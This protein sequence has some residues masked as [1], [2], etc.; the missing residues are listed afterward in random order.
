M[1]AI[2]LTP[3]FAQQTTTL[4]PKRFKQIHLRI[5]T[6][7]MNPRPPD[8]VMLD[9]ERYLVHVGPYAIVYRI[10]DSQNRIRVFL[11]VEKEE[12]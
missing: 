8:C 5:F 4:H 9:P 6:L 11:L 3:E 12:S 2:E 10:D 1:Y 7:Q